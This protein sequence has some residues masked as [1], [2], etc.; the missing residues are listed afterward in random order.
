MQN[1]TAAW[2]AA[3]QEML[4]PETFIEI[5]YDITEPGLQEQ[6]VAT[7]TMEASV[8]EAET[9][10]DSSEKDV[11]RYSSLEWNAWGLDG[12]FEYF[13]ETLPD[14]GYVTE[15]LCGEDSAFAVRPVIEIRFD[16]V[17]TVPIA[18][19]TIT[20]STAFD[21][22]AEDFQITVY[23]GTEQVAQQIITGNKDTKSLVWMGFED[24]DRIVIEVSKWCLP[25]RRARAI[26]TYVGISTTYTKNDLLNFSNSQGVD[27]L[28]AALPKN[29]LIFSLDNSNDKW[30]PDN[31]TGAE[32]YLLERQKIKL[33]YGMRVD[34]G[35]EWIKGGSFWLS[36]W[37]TPANGIEASFTA[38]DAIAFADVKYTGT[39]T[40][41]LYAIAQA[42]L[43]QLSELVAEVTYSLSEELKE[44][45]ITIADSEDDYTVSD[46]LQLVAHAGCCVL[47]Q[48]R[49]AVIHIEPRSEVLSD[50]E[51]TQDV[52]Y[53]YPEYTISKP[54]KAVEVSYGDG[55]LSTLNAGAS[56]EVQTVDNPLIQTAAMATAVGEATKELLINRKTVTGEYR[57]DP[58]L[59]AGDVIKVHSKFATNTVVITDISYSTTGGACRGRYTG[60][61]IDSG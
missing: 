50:Y 15:N 25:H 14:F 39:K 46:V 37:N 38:R 31:P 54:L 53:S 34:N 35:I 23:N 2:K 8:S 59:D 43:N 9:L 20:W 11:R 29:E 32:Q 6:A 1:V 5:S 48:D 12:S 61:V 26:S 18:G 30:N 45:S 27:L 10:T 40:G 41:T 16:T 19:V 42:A 49:D 33:R 22:W 55:Q 56:G 52:S 13:D 51:I 7:A 17:R 36:E 57:A 60:R 4:L 44:A 3:H 58:R 28:S 47:Y 24:Y 21:E